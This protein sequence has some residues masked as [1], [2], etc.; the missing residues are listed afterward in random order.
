MSGF[1]LD[2]GIRFF[3]GLGA[4]P[5]GIKDNGFSY[6]LL[7]FYSQ[8]LGLSPVLT[9]LA[10]TIAIVID[11]ITDPLIGYVSDKLGRAIKWDPVKEECVGDAE[12]DKLLKTVNYRG[13]WKFEA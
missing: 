7:I 6:F 13:D 5:Y 2:N 12:A 11:A 1:K 9:S 4:A 3:Y 10:L 8:V